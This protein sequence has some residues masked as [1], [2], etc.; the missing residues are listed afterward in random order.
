MIDTAKI[1]GT[2]KHQ[3]TG[4]TE[5]VNNTNN[6][7]EGVEV[8]KTKNTLKAW[9]FRQASLFGASL[10]GLATAVRNVYDDYVV[11]LVDKSNRQ[12]QQLEKE[13]EEVETNMINTK[14]RLEEIRNVEIPQVQ[15]EME[16]FK[17][18]I[19]EKR[20][21]AATGFT[22]SNFSMV[23]AIFYIAL[24]VV[25][26]MGLVLFYS[27][28]ICNAVFKDFNTVLATAESADSANLFNTL[29]DVKALFTIN[30]GIVLSYI[31]SAIF[32]ATG[33]ILHSDYV[34]KGKFT[35]LKSG[36]ILLLALVIELVFAYKI[37][38]NIEYMK[39]MV[40][41]DYEQAENWWN[42][43]LSVDI[44]IVIS[45][46]FVAYLVWGVVFEL[47][48][49]EYEK[50]NP[51]KLAAVII[52]EIEKKINR[53]K[54]KIGEFNSEIS[55]LESYLKLLENKL[56]GLKK[57][58]NMVY[59]NPVELEDRL[60]QFFNGWLGYLKSIDEY[61]RLVNEHQQEFENIKK[62]LLIKQETNL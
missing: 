47:G 28:L 23:K 2:K 19:E 44:F 11:S 29:I 58:L 39:S 31:F 54:Y 7:N 14:N 33:L 15:D 6:G 26:G 41:M 62:Q 56:S 51:K 43:L 48:I 3:V 22:E 25:L 42:L 38:S 10:T 40:L 52:R 17:N 37:E 18:E 5:N 36:G 53:R 9:G 50:R 24:S 20:V 4:Y 21:D 35:W 1:N 30:R 8:V 57:K 12:T 59:F 16:E 49:K 46:G 55:K 34:K 45:L 13:I 61:G 60:N 32:I 27:S